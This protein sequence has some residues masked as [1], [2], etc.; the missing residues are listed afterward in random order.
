MVAHLPWVV[1]TIIA[2]ALVLL[3][4]RLPVYIGLTPAASI[5]S[6]VGAIIGAMVPKT[7]V[8]FTTAQSRKTAVPLGFPVT[9]CRKKDRIRSFKVNRLSY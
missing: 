6:K 5:G 1:S 7:V 4:I 2:Y 8:A 3:A 9:R